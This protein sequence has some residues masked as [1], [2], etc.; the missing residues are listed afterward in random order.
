MAKH[1]KYYNMNYLFFLLYFAN[2]AFIHEFLTTSKTV[3][4]LYNKTG[5]MIET[6][7]THI[8]LKP[9]KLNNKKYDITQ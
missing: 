8:S 3:S 4:H 5:C 9:Y 7:A 1:F 2:M 6:T